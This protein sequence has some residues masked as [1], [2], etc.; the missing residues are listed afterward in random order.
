[1]NDAPIQ[2]DQAIRRL[3]NRPEF[4]RV[5]AGRKASRPSVLVQCQ[6]RPDH[7]ADVGAGFTASR[8]VGNAVVRNRA[9]RRL[10]EAVRQLL[11]RLGLPGRDYVFV[12]RRET[13]ERPW[14]LL[15]DDVGS[16]LLTLSRPPEA[17]PNQAAGRPRRGSP[18][19]T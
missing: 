11:P 10:K 14:P 12:A 5:A 18:K 8:K 16:A 15:L 1:V 7:P 4:L 3:K 19:D 17:A 13:A 6:D 9:R 2:Q